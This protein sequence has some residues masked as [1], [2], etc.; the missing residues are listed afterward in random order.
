[1]R[2]CVHVQP[3]AKEKGGKKKVGKRQRVKS[4]EQRE[5]KTT[6]VKRQTGTEHKKT[7]SEVSKS[8]QKSRRKRGKKDKEKEKVEASISLRVDDT[9]M[10]VGENELYG[11]KDEGDI[12]TAV[13]IPTDV[14]EDGQNKVDMRTRRQSRA[15]ERRLEVER[16]RAEK[17][18]LELQKQREEEE[19]ARLQ[20]E[21][22]RA[23]EERLQREAMAIETGSMESD[24]ESEEA[25]ATVD[26]SILSRLEED[27]FADNRLALLAEQQ[28]ARLRERRLL[29]AY[30]AEREEERRRREM[31]EAEEELRKARE[32][33]EAIEQKK[34]EQEEQEKEERYV[35]ILIQNAMYASGRVLVLSLIP[36]SPSQ[37]SPLVVQTAVIHLHD[38]GSN[39][40]LGTGLRTYVAYPSSTS[41]KVKDH[42]AQER[43]RTGGLSKS[44]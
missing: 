42:L 11:D 22:R 25:Q 15:E 2:L 20:E 41:R 39:K 30:A 3:Q 35:H 27:E 26:T 24:L 33:E 29:L 9:Q 14:V 31:E 4:E 21:W 19:R 8:K 32:L 23:E 36:S 44:M 37:P 6:R 5:V 38:G 1:M 18:E 34:R 12:L 16:K 17:R 13:Q 40:C 7:D 43:T 10:V 28:E